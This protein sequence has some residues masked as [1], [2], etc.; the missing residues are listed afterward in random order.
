MVFFSKMRVACLLVLVACRVPA[1]DLAGKQCPCPTD[2]SCDEA[3]NTCVLGDANQGSNADGGA[4]DAPRDARIF[5]DA[6][7]TY[8]EVVLSDHPLGYWRLGDTG[9]V[10]VDETGAHDGTY[11]GSCTQNVKGAIA[12]DPNTAVTFDGSTCKIAI[13]AAFSF[14]GTAAFSVEL[15]AAT[16]ANT[17]FQMMFCDE[18]RNAEDPIDGYALL[19]TPT[20]ASGGFQLEREIAM[21]GDKTPID[22]VAGSG[23]QHVV[24]TYDGSDLALYVNGILFGKTPDTR[25]AAAITQDALIG[26][27]MTGNPFTGTLDEVA[28]YGTALSATRVA[29]H[30]AAAQ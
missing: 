30:Y 2:Y 9:T 18:T 23:Y 4:R 7:E 16:S 14:A 22:P 11:S 25:S 24:A 19:V 10:A 6:H 27:S 13:P 20:S 28:V 15:W 17:V 12:G 26:Q 1:L 8:P 29:A 5:L 21:A 3:S